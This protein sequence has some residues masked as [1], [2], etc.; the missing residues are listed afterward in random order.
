MAASISLVMTTY[1]RERYLVDAIESVLRQ[2]QQD[3]ELLIWDDGSTD[4][5]SQ[6]A[7][8]YAQ[9][10]SRIR[11]IVAPHLGRVL[12]L[13]SAISE[14]T[15]QYLGWID[16]DDLLAPT[17][18]E[19]TAAV[20]KARSEVGLTYTSY[21]NMNE[22]GKVQG[23]GRL[24]QIPY[25]PKRLLVDFMIFHFRLIRRSVFD[26]VGGINPAFEY[27]EDYELCLR[28][29][30]VTQVHHI[31]KPLYFYRIHPNSI[32]QQK[33]PEQI[34]LCQKAIN[35]ALQRRGLDQRFEI[36]VQY[37]EERF[38][39]CRKSSARSALKT[40]CLP[41]AIF[42]LVWAASSSAVS[43]QRITPA[44]D[45]TGT[46]VNSSGNQH[47]IT[48]GQLS[49][50]RANL[51][52]SFE[53]FGL[54]Q[55]EIA[56]FISRPE[57]INILGRVTG[58]QTSVIDGML[59]VTGGNSNLFL[60]NPAGIIF[61]S[62]ATL[63]LP[64]SFTATTSTG[65]GFGSGWF[66]AV[67]ENNYRLLVGNPNAFAFTMSQPGV[68]VNAGNLSVAPGQNLSFLGGV[69]VNTGQLTAPAGQ[70]TAIA[71]PGQNTVR[72][73]QPGNVLSL[74][75]ATAPGSSQPNQ[76][77]LP[78]AALPQ[79]LTS[80]EAGQDLGLQVNPDG[81]VALVNT[82]T[83]IPTTPGTTV[84]AGRLD[85]SNAE[86]GSTGG[87]VQVLGDRVG[88]VNAQVDA[89]GNSGGGNVRIGGDYQGRGAL[90]TADRTYVSGDSRIA[91]NAGTAGNGGRVIIWSNGRTS[92]YGDISA[93][94]GQNA[95][96]G[97]FAEVSGAGQLDFQGQVDTQAPSGT[98]GT[99]L[100]DPTNIEIVGAGY[101]TG[102]LTQ[103]DQFDDQDLVTDPNFTGTR[104]SVNAL[105]FFGAN[106]ELQAKNDIIFDAAVSIVRGFNLEAR[107]GHDITVNFPIATNGGNLTLSANDPASGAAIGT[108][109]IKIN[110]NLNGNN[111]L[112]G[113]NGN[114]TLNGPIALTKNPVITGDIVNFNGTVDGNSELTVNNNSALIGFGY[115]TTFNGAV[116]NNTTLTNL[117]VNGNSTT[118]NA[119]ITTTGTQTYN[120]QTTNIG[121]II[122]IG[123]DITL[124]GNEIDF[125][126]TVSGPNRNLT[127]QPA[128]VNRPIAIGGFEETGGDNQVL[129]LSN[130]DLNAIQNGFRSITIGQANGSG[131]ITV[132][133]QAAPLFNDPINLRSPL[134]SITLQGSL[135]GGDNASV[136]L[137]G[138]TTLDERII[139]EEVGTSTIRA[140]I[141]TAGQDITINGNTTLGN[142]ATLDTGTASGNILLNGTVNGN[143]ALTLNAGR[144][145]TLGGA[146]GNTTPLT[147]LTVTGNTTLNSGTVTTTGAQ[148]YNS[149]IVLG[150]NTTLTGSTISTN[151]T[152]NG[153][154]ALTLNAD[155]VTL[156]GA[157]G[158]TTPL[159]AL[160]V[161]GNTTLNSGTITTTG[162]QTY[163]SPIALGRNTT[164]T[165][166]TINTRRTVN[167]NAALTLKADQV[168][169]GG[170]IGNSSALDSLTVNSAAN[171]NGGTIATL[172]DQTY[173]RPLTLGADTT[174]NGNDIT[175]NS[176]I[177][178]DATDTPRSLA[179]NTRE[180]VSEGGTD[181]GIT[182]L[183]GTVGGNH[184]L[185]RLTTNAEGQTIIGA[186]IT[187]SGNTMRF[188]DPVRLNAD[189]VL[190]DTS[191]NIIFNNTVDSE[192]T[193]RSLSVT[194]Q[195]GGI[196]FNG[197]VGNSN[198]LSQLTA[199]A[200]RNVT[201]GNSITTDRGDIAVTGAAIQA[202]GNSAARL[203]SRGGNV[204]LNS[205]LGDIEVESIATQG[206]NI[207]INADRF[208]RA[209]G[210]LPT[211]NR[212]STS[213]NSGGGSIAI[214]HAGGAR[215]APVAPFIV[216]DATTNGTAG[217][218]SS[219]PDNSLADQSIPGDLTQG[220]ITI[221]TDET[222]SSP[223]PPDN[224]SRTDIIPPQAQTDSVRPPSQFDIPILL[225][226]VAT[227]EDNTCREFERYFG[228]ETF[229]EL[230]GGE[231]PCERIRTPEEI[232]AL[233]SNI[234]DQAHR[235]ASIIYLIDRPNQLEVI[236]FFPHGQPVRRIIPEANRQ[237]L[238]QVVQEFRHEIDPSTP[239]G[240]IDVAK[241]SSTSYLSSARQLYQWL[242]AP[243]AKD[244]QS[245]Q[246]D[247]LVF[248]PSSGLRSLPFAALH[249]GEH[250]LVEQYSIGV[251]PSLNLI[252][253]RYQS[254][255]GSEILAVG[256]G[257]WEQ[258]GFD[259]S[260][261]PSVPVE[262][263]AVVQQPWRGQVLLNEQ[264]T[265]DKI[266]SELKNP[267]FRILHLATH[268]EFLP[269]R[270]TDSF[271]QLWNS[272]LGL[273]QLRQLSR[274]QPPVELLTLSACQTALG[275]ESA[276]LGFAGLALAAGAKSSLASL[277][278]VSDVGTLGLMTEFYR[279]LNRVPIKAE[280]L[281]QTQ[282]AMLR[283]EV[284]LEGNQLHGAT[285]TLQ[286][287]PGDAAALAAIMAEFK[288]KD[289]SHPFF[290][291]AFT[292]VGNPW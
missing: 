123:N 77:T 92:F 193:P 212:L 140:G 20:L 274:N 121:N 23:M 27:I 165:G 181:S 235:R 282:I 218:I 127:L 110:S 141:T 149:P 75:V 292:L 58:G 242:I 210:T 213:L 285:G 188:N 97:G 253:P 112:N 232:S 52:H 125:S 69:V 55:G 192:E 260:D 35:Q 223:K 78:I 252:D 194:A 135:V 245:N 164:L 204:N 216:G 198:P 205:R 231:N 249:D 250:F 256:S 173:Q 268:G 64:G 87:T 80:G 277:W 138:A 45:G 113:G 229:G 139:Q 8:A 288:V 104:L 254:L 170:A 54:S 206:G 56:N 228:S 233:L 12:A 85:V 84:I 98:T 106:I 143:A 238:L 82:G 221:D 59:R 284:R 134:G 13:K 261:L 275:D 11:A 137:N 9:R 32:T 76:W 132:N 128:T 131:A 81:Q 201:L 71:V 203:N 66:N 145:V 68:I 214:T 171:L 174:L 195:R 49:G 57:I 156:G 2:T 129:N 151:G 48:G 191:G 1:N 74:E 3:F 248:I 46:I 177:D 88:L 207:A 196:T 168:T 178:S 240:S 237:A 259:L 103:V 279:Q 241:L 263:A 63:D 93:R 147:A 179:V 281:Q 96:N 33:R 26:Q 142:A 276:E 19:E 244:L 118:L 16:D 47:D 226:E 184:P 153:N 136:T 163:N 101:N 199:T 273:N 73:S 108:G 120:G 269:G 39:L 60:M 225:G 243:L 130:T 211:R 124:T 17:A 290:W 5:S 219:S 6:I 247:T 162:A 95:G 159:T 38:L 41:L 262:V 217:R 67:G 107:A 102:D 215:Q 172:G 236:A 133:G 189:V 30:E 220:N 42:P 234:A 197:A 208:F 115:T 271:I 94:G 4:A 79:L 227:V 86:A 29:S 44:Q 31:A 100:L 186:N 119:S 15:G 50:D 278:S 51:F 258:R 265:I 166:S 224:I 14:T 152:A 37:P 90:P 200:L 24:C 239:D 180:V 146:I 62:H 246:I 7:R 161:T 255:Q 117:T 61:G 157:I 251:L 83:E 154:A 105:N 272:R 283:G 28:L 175:F 155:Q 289:L 148:T 266:V 291:A 267:S 167:G 144:Q 150:R 270:S 287:S 280:A 126:G 160:T 89:S 43:A 111:D 21:L 72:I 286:L 34:R 230:A 65:I 36:R 169:L 264:F 99:L 158:N 176:T 185:S 122:T 257:N 10:D 222:P 209:V 183:G 182:T 190:R 109:S 25:S 187:T 40:A 53:R 18:L 202:N 114:I 22:Q 116:G 70:L 91:A